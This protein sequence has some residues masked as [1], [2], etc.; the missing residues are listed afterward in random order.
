M[1]AIKQLTKEDE[2]SFQEFLKTDRRELPELH[3]APLPFPHETVAV[4]HRL[5]THG[6]AGMAQACEMQVTEVDAE[7]AVLSHHAL[8]KN[9]TESYAFSGY[10]LKERKLIFGVEELAQSDFLPDDIEGSYGGVFQKQPFD[11]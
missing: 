3:I 1:I 10:V 5:D 2:Q 8:M 11:V 4:F 9:D 6:L 7:T